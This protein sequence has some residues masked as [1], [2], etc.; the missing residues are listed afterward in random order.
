M[1]PARSARSRP[2]LVL[3][4]PDASWGGPGGGVVNRCFLAAMTWLVVGPAGLAQPLI[5]PAGAA[6]ETGPEWRYPP[7]PPRL[8]V[9]AALLTV[10][11]EG[12]D[13][14]QVALLRADRVVVASACVAG[15]GC[16][17]HLPREAA[18]ELA[19]DPQGWTVLL[20]SRK[21]PVEPGRSLALAHP[22]GTSPTFAEPAVPRVEV[23]LADP[24]FA[25]QRLDTAK[26]AWVL[27]PRVPE[28]LDRVSCERVLC[29]RTD[30]G[31]T[32]L[33]PDPGAASVRVTY[34]L[35]SGF[36][37]HVGGRFASSETLALRLERCVVNAPAWPL[38]AGVRH[39]RLPLTMPAECARP[40]RLEVQTTP[41]AGAWCSG[42]IEGAPP[43][44]RVLEVHLDEVPRDIPAITVTLFDADDHRRLGS[45]RVSVTSDFQP[46]QVRIV[47]PGLGPV[48]FIPSNRDAL[49]R[50]GAADAEW[51]D[52]LAIVDRPGFYRAR[53]Q[54]D[55]FVIRGEPGVAGH[56]PL[57]I[58]YRPEGL[59]DA[60][61]AR[62]GA[63]AVFDTDGV[64]PVHTINIPVPLVADAPG[65][66]IEARCGP[67]GSE[68][69]LT[70]GVL[71][72]LAFEQ[73]DTCRLVF[74]LD[75]LP[76]EAGV[77]RL[78][79]R[80]G[81]HERVLTLEHAE[82]HLTV[83]VG[84]GERKEYDVLTLSVAH[85]MTGDHYTLGA[86]QNLG[87]EARFRVLLSDHHVR[88]SATTAL[89]TGLFRFGRA[90]SGET[91]P[92]SAGA[93]V[94]LSYVQRDGHDF[95][96]SLEAGLFGTNLSGRADFSMVAG[97]GL[98]IPVLNPDTALQASFNIHAWFE[99]SPTRS[100]AGQGGPAFLFGPSFTIGRISTTF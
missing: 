39:Q 80:A 21:V 25:E 34:T 24:L 9:E 69:V 10:D 41:P 36:Y 68:V 48:G 53:R 83:S 14:Y 86:D 58:A 95:P 43:G 50:F 32:L 52:R 59:P 29:R 28:A 70:P 38:L 11:G 8:W 99:F 62:A 47:V 17:V 3:W 6:R 35:K 97:L 37:R 61:G 65:R 46:Q 87:E 98:G 84:A 57:R 22:D 74:A 96:V 42:E 89:P 63:V 44:T 4:Y 77:Q 76:P 88:V 51:L 78:R 16:A 33:Q 67:P 71:T 64:Y 18:D 31:V 82:G 66:F 26:D 60:P 75:R 92:I 94:R 13:G 49:V 55:A 1:W 54:G 73:R 7:T 56:V 30:R 40:G 90:G 85:D 100:R 23:V 91:V 19:R 12:L 20:V 2:L 27:T 79:V 93:L 81:D 15:E 5:A 45:V 72:R